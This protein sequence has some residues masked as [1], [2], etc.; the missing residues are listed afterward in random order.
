VNKSLTMVQSRRRV[1][2]WLAGAASMVAV[3]ACAPGATRAPSSTRSPEPEPTSTA[4]A[5]PSTTQG[6]E[7]TAAAAPTVAVEASLPSPT[8]TPA[9]SAKRMVGYLP[10]WAIG[11]DYAVGDVP[12]MNLTHLVY[13]FAKVTDT[14][15]CAMASPKVDPSAFAE[16]RRLRTNS[17]GLQMSISIGGAG[18]SDRFPNA[19]NSPEAR[20][21]FASS[22]AS[23]MKQHGFDGIDVD[24]EYPSDADQKVNFTALLVE[25][26]SQL[27]QLGQNDARHY[28]LTI[29]APAGPAHYVNLELDR[30]AS[31]VDW[32][33]LMTYAFHGT[34]SQVTNFN[35]PL[36]ASSTD[37]SSTIQRIIYNTDAA[38][39]AYLGAGVPS[40]K[41]V[42][43]VPFYGYGW[44]GVPDVNNGLYQQSAGLPDGTRVPGV[45]TYRD[46]KNRYVGTYT[47]FWHDEAQ[48]PWLYDSTA[49]V[50]ITYDDPTSVAVKANY[51]RSHGLGG[52][53]IWELSTDDVE[54]SLV[55]AIFDRLHA[56]DSA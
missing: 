24:W 54:H 53:M 20:T 10:S 14:G 43:G 11:H 47:R 1:L 50:M 15:E 49:G 19:T 16:L 35:A 44:K 17:H 48:V 18:A 9:V 21:R 56:A 42:V 36:F 13:A 27:D 7:P 23:F 37:P 46:L 3:T 30:L 39:Q 41:I 33:N 6:T 51:V 4:I 32:I 8:A 40:D 45:F 34:W 25:L 38:V 26:R 22:C 12:A 28:I 52:V 31:S 55:S 5:E 29:A 2:G